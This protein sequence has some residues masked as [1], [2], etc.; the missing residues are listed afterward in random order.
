MGPLNRTSSLEHAWPARGTKYLSLVAM[1]VLIPSW[2]ERFLLA[3][4]FPQTPTSTSPPCKTETFPPLH[5]QFL[6]SSTLPLHLN[7]PTRAIFTTYPYLP[8]PPADT[9]RSKRLTFAIEPSIPVRASATPSPA[10]PLRPRPPGF[11]FFEHTHFIHPISGAPLSLI[12]SPAEHIPVRR[13]VTTS[14]ALF[15]P[16]LRFPSLPRA[17]RLHG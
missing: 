8:T 14:R 4:A 7:R 17:R 12:A 9:V 15:E 3:Q 1:L 5:T 11:P 13:L 6:L 16:S 10:A 2:R